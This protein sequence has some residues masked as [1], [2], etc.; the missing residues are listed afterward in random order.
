MGGM[1]PFCTYKHVVDDQYI[2]FFFCNELEGN[3]TPIH[4]CFS[5]RPDKIS[6]IFT[7]LKFPYMQ[8]VDGPSSLQSLASVR[9][10]AYF[11][12]ATAQNS[13]VVV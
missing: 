7:V 5:S 6:E 1:G 9:S 8:H 12:R 13:I 10:K 11:L 4:R 3:K 2:I